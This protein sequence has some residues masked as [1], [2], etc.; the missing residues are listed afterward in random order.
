MELRQVN[1]P[2]TVRAR[3]Q[4]GELGYSPRSFAENSVLF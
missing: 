2:V 3:K 4:C 1:N